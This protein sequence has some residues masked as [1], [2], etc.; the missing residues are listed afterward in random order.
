MSLLWRLCLWNG[1]VL[2]VSCSVMVFSPLTLAYP[3]APAE[4]VWIL[5]GILGVWGANF[6]TVWIALRPLSRLAGAMA[7]VDTPRPGGR[8]PVEGPGEVG[9]LASTFNEMLDRLD[10][11]RATAVRATLLGQEDERSRV[12]A[13]LHDEVGQSLTVVLL[14][15]SR[16][17]RQAPAELVDELSEI[18]EATRASLDMVRTI[19]ARLRP[20]V[21][22]DLGLSR[23]ISAVAGE[24][25]THAG[26][27]L[28]REIDE[29]SG[30]THEQDL[31]LYRVA[32][33]ALTN[34]ARHANATTVGVR[35]R[36]DPRELRLTVTDDGQGIRSQEGTGITG[37]RERARLVRG[38]LE[39]VSAPGRGTVV[40]LSVPM[41]EP[42]SEPMS[43]QGE[44]R[45][46]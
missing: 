21:L 14:R 41:S 16:A 19:T 9:R 10:A 5:A 15:L 31:V 36:R 22:D 13:E 44:G 40:S 37:M 25:A 30:T 35:L 34:A 27:Q 1:V 39:I 20:G 32:Q 42:R 18:T 8:V 43:D 2:L 26:L 6:L 46:I 12:A 38:A 7:A 3:L 17:S 11:E 24:V 45:R 23:A 33:E 4:D 29:V 28:R